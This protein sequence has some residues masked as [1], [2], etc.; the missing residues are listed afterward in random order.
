MGQTVHGARCHGASCHGVS[1]HGRD[2]MGRVVMGQVVVREWN[3]HVHVHA[4]SVCIIT[5]MYMYMEDPYMYMNISTYKYIIDTNKYNI[6]FLD[7]ILVKKLQ[8]F[9][10]F[11]DILFQLNCM[12]STFMCMFTEGDDHFILLR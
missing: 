6:P 9:E 2:F 11:G 8:N 3:P 5:C 1:C 12:T 10:K 7:K 4:N